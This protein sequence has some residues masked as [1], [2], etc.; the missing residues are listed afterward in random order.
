VPIERFPA[1]LAKLHQFN[2]P[3]NVPI[4][5]WQGPGGGSNV[6]I[7]FRLLDS[8]LAL[9]G[10]VAECGVWKASTLLPVGLFLRQ[11][12]SRKTVLGF[13]SFEG[14]NETVNVDIGLGGDDE[15]RKHI[16]GF[17]DTSYDALIEKT[18]RFGVAETVRLVKGYFQ[19][20]LGAH[21]DRRFCFVHL[22]C[23][24]YE[25]Y[26]YCLAFFYP[27]L[28][29]GGIMLIDEYKDPPWPGCTRAVDEFLAD[30]PEKLEEIF[31]DSQV[32]FYFRKS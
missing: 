30:K 2:V 28:V 13:D 9:N 6:R 27:R 5:D 8:V 1:W 3:N 32:K 12:G 23:V 16:G 31:S 29:Q 21:A 22:D 19:D 26:K 18:R 4:R 20:S 15:D 24:I 14:L 11:R 17:G 7:I 10:D 25:S